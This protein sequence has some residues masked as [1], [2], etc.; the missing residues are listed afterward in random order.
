MKKIMLL[1][2]FVSS[3]FALTDNYTINYNKSQ[4]YKKELSFLSIYQD[5]PKPRKY[6]GVSFEKLFSNDLT[7]AAVG[8]MDFEASGGGAGAGI[9]GGG[10]SSGSVKVPYW[11]ALGVGV[12]DMVITDYNQYKNALTSGGNGPISIAFYPQSSDALPLGTV[13]DSRE[14]Y[15]LFV[16]DVLDTLYASI[17]LKAGLE[18]GQEKVIY[19]E[20][21]IREFAK[22][23]RKV[24]KLKE[25]GFNVF[26][27]ENNLS[28]KHY[29]DLNLYVFLKNEDVAMLNELQSQFIKDLS[30]EKTKISFNGDWNKIVSKQFNLSFENGEFEILYQGREV[31]TKSSYFGYS[32]NI[33]NNFLKK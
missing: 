11:M 17:V 33:A 24:D 5:V 1:I 32:L 10:G 27:V 19:T 13:K 16:R 22:N 6:Y 29:A 23:K 4:Q 31:Y 3:V 14:S 28:Y 30:D 15:Y 20:A 12:N 25:S 21:E 26:R 9:D 2:A 7:R 18:R 8:K